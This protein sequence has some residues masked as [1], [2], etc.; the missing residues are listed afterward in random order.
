M[1]DNL[2]YT[3]MIQ[4]FKNA[5]GKRE[6]PVHLILLSRMLILIIL[7]TIGLSA[8]SFSLQLKFV[9]D[10]LNIG[11][12]LVSVESRNSQL[13]QLAINVRSFSNIANGIEFATY[14]DTTLSRINRF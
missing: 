4:D 8:A 9:K 6:T 3:K 5:I 2:N 10:S 1:M 12:Q 13:I 14:N 7:I 11:Q